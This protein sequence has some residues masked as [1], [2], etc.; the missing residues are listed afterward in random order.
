MTTTSATYTITKGAC[1]TRSH[2]TVLFGEDQ[3]ACRSTKREATAYTTEQARCD[4][5]HH[6]TTTHG[7]CPVC[8]ADQDLWTRCMAAA[9]TS[10]LNDL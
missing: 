10:A 4:R 9:T 2:W 8:S 7:L 3:V 1:G 5:C 6:L